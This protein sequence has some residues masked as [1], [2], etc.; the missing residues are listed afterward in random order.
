MAL[1]RLTVLGRGIA[2][3]IAA[4]VLLAAE[5]FEAAEKSNTEP[6]VLHGAGQVVGGLLFELPRTVIEAT[7]TSPPVVGTVV[8]LFAGTARALQV[9]VGGLVEMAAGFNPGG[10]QRTRRR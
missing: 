8:G 3:G 1:R 2:F 9:T 10:A 5:S 7:M 6:S 4:A